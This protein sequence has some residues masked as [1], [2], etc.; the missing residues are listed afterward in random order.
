VSFE[1]QLRVAEGVAATATEPSP[2]V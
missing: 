1:L 2:S